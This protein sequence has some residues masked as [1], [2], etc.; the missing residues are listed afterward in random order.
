MPTSFLVPHD[1]TTAADRI[2]LRRRKL[3][4]GRSAQ[5][6]LVVPGDRV[7]RHHARLTRVR[8]GEYIVEDLG[9]VHG[10][11]VN[12]ER[13]YEPHALRSG[14]VL[15]LAGNEILFRYEQ[16]AAAPRLV[17]AANRLLPVGAGLLALTLLVL[18]WG[19]RP[20][21]NL[22]RA[23]HLVQQA[24][25]ARTRGDWLGVQREL[26]SAAGVLF[27]AGLLGETHPDQ[28]VVAAL[29][30]LDPGGERALEPMLREA[31]AALRA[32]S[33]SLSPELTSAPPQQRCRLDQSEVSRLRRCLRREVDYILSELGESRTTVPDRWLP[34]IGRQL[35]ERRDFFAA[36]LAQENEVV[37]LLRS[38]LE[39]AGISPLFHYLAFIESAYRSRAD[40]H[41][42]AAGIWQFIPATARRYQLKVRDGIDERRDPALATQAAAAYLR[43]LRAHFADFEG[44]LLLAIA[45]YNY[46]EHKV[47][48]ALKKLD[49]PFGASPYW[50]LVDRGLLPKETADYAP[51][52]LAAALAGESGLPDA[53]ALREAGLSPAAKP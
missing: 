42:G 15:G 2:M 14:D 31:Q 22:R 4:I 12:G 46:G 3:R 25:A 35:G 32:K 19:L 51:R 33:L 1:A 45:G 17:F 38:E 53:A 49:N 48:R 43:D 30:L 18:V 8:A 40:S 26:R 11:F 21:P 47:D 13:L 23:E 37:P 36:I 9:S 52:F 7:S 24:E 41:A 50:E 29:H 44:S 10:T 28:P 5:C 6:D 16:D 34:Y 20:D 27:Q 39:A